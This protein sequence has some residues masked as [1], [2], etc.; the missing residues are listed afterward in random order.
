[1][2]STILGA[3]K[4][5]SSEDKELANKIASM[6]VTDMRT[7]VN[8]KISALPIS[9]NGLNE[10]MKKL[11]SKN[12]STSRGFLEIDDMDIK[13]KKA[14][15]LVLLIGKNNK[16]SI[17]TVEYIQQFADQYKDII[18]KF[19]MDKKEIYASRFSKLIENLIVKIAG[20]VEFKKKMDVLKD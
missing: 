14:F 2:L 1:M 18:E 5:K 13:I 15:D 10:V 4:S 16:A 7:Y 11:I 8:N 17:Q 6:S 19:D 9:E 12:E 3:K 20:A